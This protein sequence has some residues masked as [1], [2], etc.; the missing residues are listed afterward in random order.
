MNIPRSTALEIFGLK[1]NFSESD[2]K[3]EYRRLVKIIHPDTGGDEK[4]FKFIDE[5]KKLLMNDEHSSEKNSET[6]NHNVSYNKNTTYPKKEEAY[7]TL[8]CLDDD[9]NFISRY[10]SQYNITEIRASLLIY[11]RPIFRKNL[12]Q[13]INVSVSFPYSKFNKSAGFVKFNQT[14]KIPSEMQKF[15]KFKVRI[16]FLG[17]TFKFIVCDGNFRVIEH[18]KYQYIQCLKSIC[19]LHF[20]K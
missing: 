2:L 20:A 4:L 13:C 12:E 9:Y 11:I 1:E 7:I 5:C 15:R 6:G 18:V 19:E 14:I 16:K 3:R 10:E 17:D 8:E